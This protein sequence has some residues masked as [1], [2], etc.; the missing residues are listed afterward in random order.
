MWC[1]QTLVLVPH[2]E[3]ALARVKVLFLDVA[4]SEATPVS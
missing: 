1:C 4:M 2:E 3:R